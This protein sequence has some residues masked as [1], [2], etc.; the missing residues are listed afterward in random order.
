MT[1]E[2]KNSGRIFRKWKSG[3]NWSLGFGH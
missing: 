1:N 3:G 2:E